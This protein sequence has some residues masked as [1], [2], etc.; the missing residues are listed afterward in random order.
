MAYH[1]HPVVEQTG[2]EG[3]RKGWGRGSSLS[4]GPCFCDSSNSGPKYM[5][6]KLPYN[7][8]PAV[9][10]L[11]S[12]VSRYLLSI[13]DADR[14]TDL[15]PCLWTFKLLSWCAKNVCCLC[16]LGHCQATP[17]WN[18]LI[19]PWVHYPCHAEIPQYN[20]EVKNLPK[21]SPPEHQQQKP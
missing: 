11:S 19:K 2:Q 12:L 21:H 13:K 14:H 10:T 1:T 9:T 16:D 5:Y 20:G 4:R 17:R 7:G 8:T 15:I 18:D 6:C 3:S